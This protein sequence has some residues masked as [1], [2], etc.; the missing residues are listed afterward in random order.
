MKSKLN[1]ALEDLDKAFE[2]LEVKPIS[3]DDLS[4]VSAG[5]GGYCGDTNSGLTCNFK[6]GD[7]GWWECP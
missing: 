4:R 1:N 2:N 5:T 6:C 3:N 7:T